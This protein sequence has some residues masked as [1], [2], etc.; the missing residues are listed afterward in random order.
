MLRRFE[1]E[2]S[3]TLARRADQVVIGQRCAIIAVATIPARSDPPSLATGTLSPNYSLPVPWNEMDVPQTEPAGLATIDDGVFT[4]TSGGTDIGGQFD[5]FAFLYQGITGDFAI[6][7]RL[8]KLTGGDPNAKAG[9]I[10]RDALASVTNFAASLATVSH[11]FEHAY[12]PYYTPFAAANSA[13]ASIPLWVKLIKQGGQVDSYLAPDSSG[14][15]GAWQLVGS[16]TPISTGLVF[17]G[18]VTASHK[19]GAGCTAVFDH[20]S[21]DLG[22][23]PELPEGAYMLIPVS[24]GLVLEAAG[25]PLS[26]APTAVIQQ[27][28]NQASQKWNFVKKGNAGYEIQSGQNNSLVLSASGTAFHDEDAIVLAPD[29]GGQNQMWFVVENA[30]GTYG[31]YSAGDAMAGVDDK[32]GSKRPGSAMDLLHSGPNDPT[33]QWKII[34]LP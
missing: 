21:V 7:A 15:P 18:L 22:P 29:K 28:H 33:M 1:G 34:P 24:C 20:V 2:Q 12:R 16:S 5:N 14:S 4:L 27:W 9:V 10:A 8:S 11:G 19:Q 17:V 31:L 6:T 3:G 13:A 30:N 25:P 23:Y 26:G 32:E